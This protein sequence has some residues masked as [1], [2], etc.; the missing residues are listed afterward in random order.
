MGVGEGRVLKLNMTTN[1][2]KMFNT[3]SSECPS[4]VAV[5]LLIPT[6]CHVHVSYTLQ[7]LI[8]QG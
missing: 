4:D 6:H 7:L 8:L 2:E 5:V 1:T 3:V